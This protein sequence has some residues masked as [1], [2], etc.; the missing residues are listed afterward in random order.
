MIERLSHELQSL[1]GQDQVGQ[2]R[3][4]RLHLLRARLALDVAEGLAQAAGV[5]GGD[6]AEPLAPAQVAAYLDGSLP[7]DEWQVVANRL[8]DDPALRADLE[9]TVRLKQRAQRWLKGIAAQ[10]QKNSD[11]SV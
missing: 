4:E 2:D 6:D 10:L 5:H 8:A 11:I 1:L 9:S 3:N 7:P